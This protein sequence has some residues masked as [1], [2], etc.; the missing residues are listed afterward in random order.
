MKITNLLNNFGSETPKLDLIRLGS[1]P[2][3]VVPF[4]DEGEPVHTHFLFDPDCKGYCHCNQDESGKGCVLC[5]LGYERREHF[6]LPV[7]VPERRRVE[8]LCMS[9]TKT[10]TALLPKVQQALQNVGSDAAQLWIVSKTNHYD[11]KLELRALQPMADDGAAVVGAFQKN[12]TDGKLKVVDAIPR[13]SDATLR[14]LNSV[15]TKLRLLG[16]VA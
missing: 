2:E 9:L 8:A 14:A 15:A 13:H 5:R 11:F 16:D 6:L 12:L 3:F 10:P 7:Y 4:T 1:N